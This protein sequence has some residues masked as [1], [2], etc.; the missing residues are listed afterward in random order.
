MEEQPFTNKT[1]AN[2][3]GSD[4][5]NGV[6]VVGSGGTAEV[7]V[8]TSAGL[9]ISRD[10]GATFSNKTRIDGLGNNIC[11]GVYVVGSGLSAQIFAS[12][13]NGLQI[14]NP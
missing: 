9:S 10:G 5:V 7:Y 12:T 1:I 2:G 4:S 8:A 13:I 11:N 6:Y 14:R 3:L